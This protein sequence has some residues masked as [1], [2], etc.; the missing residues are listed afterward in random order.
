MQNQQVLD[1]LIVKLKEPP[2]DVKFIVIGRGNP[3][4]MPGLPLPS[5][6]LPLTLKGFDHFFF[7]KVANMINITWYIINL[8]ITSWI[9]CVF[10]EL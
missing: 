7:L 2:S 8:M 9:L 10:I 1:V 4:V 3:G 6:P 5:I